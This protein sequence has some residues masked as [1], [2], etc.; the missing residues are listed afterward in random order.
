MVFYDFKI[1]LIHLSTIKLRNIICVILSPLI[2]LLLYMKKVIYKKE[3]ITVEKRVL[4]GQSSPKSSLD[5]ELVKSLGLGGK[6]MPNI[7]GVIKVDPKHMPNLTT[8]KPLFGCALLY[9]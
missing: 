1:F 7:K 6:G 3:I 5:P 2:C 9:I 8:G 4:N